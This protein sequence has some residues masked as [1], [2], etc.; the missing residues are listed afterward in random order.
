MHG[1]D[2]GDRRLARED[3]G[4][5]LGV[6]NPAPADKAPA[7]TRKIVY[8]AELKMIV[9]NLKQ[10]E[11]TL[12]QI[13]KD[14]D[15]YIAQS[16]RSGAGT[17]QRQGTWTLRVPVDQFQSCVDALRELGYPQRDKTDSKDVSEEYYDLEARIK[18]KQTEESRL[19]SYLEEKKATSKLDDILAIERE[20]NRVRGEVEQLQGRLRLLSNIT[21]L[22]TINL[23]LQE[24][25]DYVP[26]QPGFGGQI[27]DT[28]F[29][30]LGALQACGKAITLAAVALGP[31]LP[32]L[33][34]VGVPV[35]LL[36]RRRLR[37]AR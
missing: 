3:G 10:A 33:A 14:H 20:L 28:F 27:A 1:G 12:K 16:D 8:T 35:W 34:V 36:L 19:Q 30:S 18:N 4:A 11:D 31:W 5:Q 21:A 32:V 25:K 15:A 22:A 7:P 26:P 13:V 9:D 24:S 6:N 29:G 2:D 23:S 17:P 37:A